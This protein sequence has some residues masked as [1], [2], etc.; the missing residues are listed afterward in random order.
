[1][2]E[3]VPRRVLSGDPVDPRGAGP[4]TIL[5]APM[6]VDGLFILTQLE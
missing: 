2:L 4:R 6:S 1:M 5:Y 3:G